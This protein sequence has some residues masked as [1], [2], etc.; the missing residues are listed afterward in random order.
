[1]PRNKPESFRK[2]EAKRLLRLRQKLG[3]TQRDMAVEF[4]STP[5]A[6]A[7]WETG[8]RTISGPVLRLIEVYESGQVK[9]KKAP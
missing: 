7:L 4:N 6:I 3:F 9:P 5:S 1:M 2:V 8:D